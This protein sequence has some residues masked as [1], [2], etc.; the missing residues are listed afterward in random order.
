MS[1][2]VEPTHFGGIWAQTYTHDRTKFRVEKL[3][4][5]SKAL[6]GKRVSVLTINDREAFASLFT[7]EGVAWVRKHLIPQWSR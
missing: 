1:D 5:G 3:T 6:V 2:D 7:D 4:V